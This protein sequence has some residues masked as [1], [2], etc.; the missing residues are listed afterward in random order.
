MLSCWNF[1]FSVF[2]QG[3]LDLKTTED[4]TQEHTDGKTGHYLADSGAAS[5]E[6]IVC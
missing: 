2:N 1:G 3:P 4:K 5:G 6:V